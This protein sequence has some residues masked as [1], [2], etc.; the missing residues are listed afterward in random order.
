MQMLSLKIISIRVII[1]NG[2]ECVIVLPKIVVCF[3][4]MWQLT[5][6]RLKGEEIRRVK[7]RISIQ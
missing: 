4:I 7:A 2:K 3:E 1:K 5:G 6:G